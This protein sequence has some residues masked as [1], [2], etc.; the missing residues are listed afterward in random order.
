M[1][2]IKQDQIEKRLDHY[3]KMAMAL[4]AGIAAISPA[5]NASTFNSSG[6][7]LSGALATGST[8]VYF[9]PILLI[10]STT[11]FNTTGIGTGYSLEST[12]IDS[13]PIKVTLQPI[14]NI[15]AF[16]IIQ[17][18]IQNLTQSQFGSQL[19]NHIDG[20]SNNSHHYSTLAYQGAS[21]GKFNPADGP[22]SG[23]IALEM[24]AN[25]NTYYGWAE[26][27]V[28]T[29]Y[30]VSLLGYGV[31]GLAGGAVDFTTPEPGTPSLLLIG[32]GAIGLG[33]YRRKRKK[34]SEA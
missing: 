26:I 15:D 29:D 4:A 13:G 18:S 10:S 14:G 31:E 17:S 1:K 7:N 24:F 25:S 30:S 21:L 20:Y 2:D 27:Q 6:I 12:S 32:L 23:Y 16:G 5:A 34:N 33:A 9:D 19:T 28:N 22:T 8:T 3:K 11:S